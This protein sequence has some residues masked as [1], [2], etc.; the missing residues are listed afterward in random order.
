MVARVGLEAVAAAGFCSEHIDEVKE[1]L[2]TLPG[3]DLTSSMVVAHSHWGE[4]VAGLREAGE[5]LMLL[6]RASA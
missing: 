5:E 6:E 2:E 3:A 4:L 1:R